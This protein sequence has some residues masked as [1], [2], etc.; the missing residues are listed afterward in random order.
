MYKYNEYAYL[1][2]E[3]IDI[4]LELD[5]SSHLKENNCKQEPEESQVNHCNCSACQSHFCKKD[6][7]QRFFSVYDVG[8]IVAVV[9]V[10]YGTRNIMKVAVISDDKTIRV[11]DYCF[12]GVNYIFGM[13]GGLNVL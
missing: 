10:I 9:Y 8:K 12:E 5:S 3:P 4:S 2:D 6:K 7:F 13:V 1:D 11:L